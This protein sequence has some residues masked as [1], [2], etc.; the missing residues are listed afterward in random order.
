[1][2]FLG[3]SKPVHI[4]VA[5]GEEEEG[6]AGGAARFLEYKTDKGLK[7]KLPL[8]T[9]GDTIKGTVTIEPLTAKRVDHVGIRIQLLGQI[10]ILCDK[11]SNQDFIAKVRELEGPGEFTNEE[12]VIPF[13]FTDLDLPHETYFGNNIRVKYLLKI[14]VVRNYAANVVKEVPFCVRNTAEPSE[15]G[16]SIKMEVG[17]EDCLHIEFEYD[18]SKFHLKDT[19]IGKIYFLLVRIKL[20]HMEIELKRRET[21]GVGPNSHNESW[22]IAKYEVMDG[23]PVKGEH[24]PL[25]LFLSPWSE[26]LTPTYKDVANKFS[27]RY[28]LNLVLVDEEDR[29]YFKQQ[30]ITLYR[31]KLQ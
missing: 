3:L 15:I 17:I 29:R 27:V 2:N 12:K 7:E 26:E 8:Y 1:M 20:K 5:L 11:G 16:Q 25:R 30:E 21:A 9:T 4:R 28:F 19:L 18:K 13:E 23:A 10:E 6:G 22:T 14:T 31:S 24:V